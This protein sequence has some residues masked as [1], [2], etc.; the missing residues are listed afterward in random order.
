M[1]KN[2][3]QSRYKWNISQQNNGH[4]W[5]STTNII[6]KGGKLK[7]FP[8]KLPFLFYRVLE[9]LCC[10]MLSHFSCVQQI[11]GNPSPS[12]Q[13]LDLSSQTQRRQWHP[14]PVLFS[15]K[16]HGRRSLEGCSP[17]GR[18]GSDMTEWLHFHFSLSC[19]GEGMTTHSSVLA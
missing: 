13:I 19:I 1:K 8:V 17:W 15:G 3:K 10:A 9:V 12:N 6:P 11:I 2:F 18:W 16:S 4:L 7:A 14:I 5:Q